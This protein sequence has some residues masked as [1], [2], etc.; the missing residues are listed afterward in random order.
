[1]SMWH[2]CDTCRQLARGGYMGGE[3]I[4]NAFLSLSTITEYI[5]VPV[6][7]IDTVVVSSSLSN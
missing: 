1:M 3:G 5:Y 7:H 2:A 4:G 6:G